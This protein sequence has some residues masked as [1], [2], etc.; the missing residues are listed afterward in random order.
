MKKA[1]KISSISLCLGLAILM[2]GC[3]IDE[4]GFS[5]GIT[6]SATTGYENLP[7]TR[8]IYSGD[9]TTV[10]GAAY[11]RIDWEVNDLIRVVSD[12]AE[13]PGGDNYA[14]Y[15][16]TG[17]ASSTTQISK[18]TVA[19]AGSEGLNWGSGTN[20]FFAMYPAPSTT[21]VQSGTAISLSGTTAT[22]SG[23]IPA[24][25]AVTLNSTAGKYLPDMRYAYMW[26][27]T[28][29][30]EGSGVELAFKPAMTA[31][32]FTFGN[33]GSPNTVLLKKFELSSTS[34]ALT[35]AFTGS[36]AAATPGTCSFAGPAYSTSNNKITVNF[37]T[38]VDVSATKYVTFDV[39]ALPLNITDL[40]VT[41]TIES[42]GV[43]S[44]KSMELKEGSA[45]I[46]FSANK[47]YRIR[48]SAPAPDEPWIYVIEPADIDT[49]KI[50]G[51]VAADGTPVSV[52]SYKYKASDPTNKVAVPWELEYA[53]SGSSSWSTT[54]D[55]RLSVSIPMHVGGTTGE[56]ATP[57]I[58]RDHYS[59]EKVENQHI[60]DIEEAATAALRSRDA[61]GTSSTP[62]DLSTHPF[63]GS[64]ITTTVPRE[65]ANC[66]V[67]SRPGYY[68]IPLV[69]GNAIKNGAT[70]SHSYQGQ[71]AYDT[72]N[73][74]NDHFMRTFLRHDNGKIVDPWISGNGIAVTNAVVVWQDVANADTQ[75]ILDSDLSINGDYLDFEVKR[76]H[77]RPGNIVIAARNASNVIVWSWHIWVIE[78]DLTPV[79]VT[80][81]NGVTHQMMPR[82][83]G[84]TDKA[85]GYGSKWNDWTFDIR[86][87]QTETG[88]A[89]GDRFTVKQI[90]ETIIV[91]PNVG[92][93]TFYQWGRKDPMLPAASSSQNKSY[94]SA[95]GFVLTI[96]NTHTV[97]DT[98]PT[99][100]EH[101]TVGHSI[102][103]PH[104]QYYRK[105]TA[106]N[107]KGTYLGGADPVLIGNLWDADLIP[108][109]NTAIGTPDPFDNRL[110]VKTVYDPCPPGFCVPYGYFFGAFTRSQSDWVY[111]PISGASLITGEGWRFNSSDNHFLP[112][113]GARGGNGETGIFDVTNLGYYWTTAPDSRNDYTYRA[114]AKYLHLA[115]EGALRAR[116][117][118]DKAACYAIR[119]VKEQ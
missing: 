40:T 107:S 1:I 57:S 36:I 25:Q 93:N 49:I 100:S 83:L 80:D 17:V 69:Y 71:L 43:T 82:N 70:N 5:K 112:F 63:Y 56:N 91:N 11:E 86:I 118:Q 105:V 65:T 3:Q 84:W 37:G 8:T 50:Y 7:G 102:Q 16:I 74:D 29:S 108:Y 58:T 41:L 4:W 20:T 104:K 109:T 47:K 21:G 94:Y 55:S 54:P 24:T 13:T 95:A 39:L 18:A 81:L 79:S 89:T 113:T 106:G 101:V 6:F 66:Y 111:P 115:S 26:A 76:E 46:P 38:G 117:D 35:G 51:H 64:D 15:K 2:T 73:N 98:P 60:D 67:I 45:S 52:K 22:I 72:G 10:S 28:S 59:T 31:F 110:P 61:V 33:S 92:S 87:K 42:Q 77:I 103:N 97:I 114:C 90:G 85:S 32:E 27:A 30:T 19:N 12:V 44:V 34:C 99:S 9:V 68:R 75:I 48:I 62:F 88:G 78:T 96:D 23:S 116:N 14:D 53:A 119:A